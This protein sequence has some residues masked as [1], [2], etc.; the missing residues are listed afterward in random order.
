MSQAKHNV[1]ESIRHTSIVHY[2]PRTVEDRDAY[3]A[4]LGTLGREDDVQT[5]DQQGLVLIESWGTTDAGEEWRVHV[6]G[7]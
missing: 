4:D 3:L 2:Y 7:P 6:H 1:E 5:E